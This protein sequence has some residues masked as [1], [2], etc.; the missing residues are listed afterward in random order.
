MRSVKKEKYLCDSIEAVAQNYGYNFKMTG[1]TSMPYPWFFEDD[2]LYKIQ[3]FCMFASNKGLFFH[4][5]H[6]WFISNAHDKSSLES[7]L[8]LVTET[9]HEMANGK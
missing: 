3:E 6:N 9:F 2:D 1:P 8:S 4:P 7:A 5:H